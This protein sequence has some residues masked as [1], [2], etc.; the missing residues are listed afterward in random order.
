MILPVVLGAAVP[1][2]GVFASCARL[3]V[4]IVVFDLAGMASGGF[5]GGGEGGEAREEDDDGGMHG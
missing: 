5:Y 4:A 1:Q 2:A 3:D